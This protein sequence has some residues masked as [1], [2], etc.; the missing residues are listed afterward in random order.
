MKRAFT[1]IELI[2]VIIV[3]GI[4]ASVALP[5][6]EESYKQSLISKAQSKVTAIRS[7]LQVYKNKHILLGQNPFPAS[8]DSDNNHLFDQVLP[9]AVTPG[10]DPGEWKKEGNKYKFLLPSNQYIVFEY[11]NNTGKFLC[12][13]NLSSSQE[14][15]NHF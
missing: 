7:G 12:N 13:P 8:L 3:I 1:I 11:N 14:L 4:L 9:D 10:T 5:R 6:F 15:C 2:F